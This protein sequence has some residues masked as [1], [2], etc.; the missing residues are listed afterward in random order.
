MSSR[1]ISVTTTPRPP[2]AGD[3]AVRDQPGDGRAQR[4]ARDPQPFG[5]L[6]FR[7]HGTGKQ[8]PFDDV[9]AQG[10]IGLIAGRALAG[11]IG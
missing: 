2:A 7:Q 5:L 8:A 10:R 6:H 4:G 11:P 1:E 3:Q 9:V